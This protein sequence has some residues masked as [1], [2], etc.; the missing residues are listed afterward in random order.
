MLKL[1]IEDIPSS[2]LDLREVLDK[3]WLK[4]ISE[5]HKKIENRFISPISLDLRVAKLGR[6]IFVHG[7]IATDL[8]MECTRCLKEFDYPL[9]SDFKYTFCPATDKGIADDVELTSE[10]LEFSFYQGEEI[11]ISQVILEEIILAISFN[12]LCHEL[13]RG[14][15][16]QCG[17]DLNKESCKCSKE[18]FNIR[19]SE[20]RD[21]KVESRR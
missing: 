17:K 18:K 21:F 13:C 2:G 1:K 5:D 14:L 16:H 9:I 4:G 6:D 8:I 7:S 15:C 10:D 19:F 3:D 20:L 11:D 12:P